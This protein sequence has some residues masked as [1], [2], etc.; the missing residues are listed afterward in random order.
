MHTLRRLYTLYSWN[1]PHHSKSPTEAKLQLTYIQI[2]NIYMYIEYYSLLN[3]KEILYLS[4]AINAA[5]QE[6]W[7][8]HICH[9]IAN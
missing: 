6:L 8:S 3:I 5:S 9:K 1:G 7:N 2:L 4:D